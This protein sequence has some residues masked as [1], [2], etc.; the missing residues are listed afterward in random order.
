[1]PGTLGSTEAEALER[2]CG[3]RRAWIRPGTRGAGLQRLDAYL[4]AGGSRP[5]RHA[6]YGIGIP[7]AG[8]QTFRYRGERRICLPGQLHVLH[9][10]ETHDGAAASSAGFGYRI[11]YVTPGL[12]R[13]ALG[14][15][16]PLPFV[17]DPVQDR[18]RVPRH[19]AALLADLDQP[20]S[21]LARRAAA[22]DLAAPGVGPAGG[23][24]RRPAPTA[25]AAVAAARDYLD[26]HAREQ[27]PSPPLERITGL[28]RFSL[29]RQ[30]RRAYGTSPDRYRTLRRLD[31]ARTAIQAGTPIA[32][33]AADTGFA[34]QR[35]LTRQFTRPSAPPPPPR[36]PP[37]PTPMPF[38]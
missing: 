16:A 38:R 8:V 22:A 6:T 17:P 21:E 30:F 4:R 20:L 36:T 34:A 7:T 19:L 37:V 29:A 31:L 13:G 28:D 5:H 32:Q 25:R 35:H 24:A 10:D 1:M 33:A 14:D 26:A 27:T 15:R 9:P 18:A 12:I 11:V 23:A 2:S 3:P